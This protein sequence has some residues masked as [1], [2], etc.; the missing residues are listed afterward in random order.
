M[1][2]RLTLSPVTSTARPVLT[3]S[4]M[5]I[6]LDVMGRRTDWNGMDSMTISRPCTIST[7]PLYLSYLNPG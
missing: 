3:G 6:N 1:L 5:W 7:R 2:S 4:S